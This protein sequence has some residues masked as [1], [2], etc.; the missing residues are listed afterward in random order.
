MVSPLT[1]LGVPT[2]IFVALRDAGSLSPEDVAGL[3][4]W[5]PVTD[6]LV[7]PEL[8]YD[9]NGEIVMGFVTPPF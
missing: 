4:Y 5:A 9:S 2:D 1:R 7:P 8:L 3:G 6:G